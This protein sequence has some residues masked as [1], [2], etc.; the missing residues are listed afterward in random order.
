MSIILHIL[1]A[2]QSGVSP[3]ELPQPPAD[4]A[5]LKDILGIVFSVIG[6]LAVL[7]I[8]VSGLRYTL[9]GGD[10]GKISK[11][12]NGIAYALVGLLV[13]ITAEAIVSFVVVAQ[14]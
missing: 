9:A 14:K 11:A 13:A 10:E 6:A 1:A 4:P 5:A 3:G 12:K 2:G 7:M 8:T